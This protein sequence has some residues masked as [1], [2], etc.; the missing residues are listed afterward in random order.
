[1]PSGIERSLKY[2]ISNEVDTSSVAATYKAMAAV[3][4]AAD[5]QK[6]FCLAEMPAGFCNTSFL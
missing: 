4:A 2:G 3:I 6:S 5:C 1:M